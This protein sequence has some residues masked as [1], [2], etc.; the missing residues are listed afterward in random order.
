[1]CGRHSSGVHVWRMISSESRHSTPVFGHLKACLWLFQSR[2]VAIFCRTGS[3]QEEKSVCVAIWVIAVNAR[4]CLGHEGWS[5]ALLGSTARSSSFLGHTVGVPEAQGVKVERTHVPY[6]KARNF[7][8][9]S[10]TMQEKCNAK[11]M[12]DECRIFRV[13]EVLV[14]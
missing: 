14:G 3:E 6:Q 8:V 11:E 9:H 7:G 12:Q 2:L 1:M 13:I 10:E 4:P 5:A